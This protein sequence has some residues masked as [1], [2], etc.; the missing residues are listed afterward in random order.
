MKIQRY[1]FAFLVLY[2]S[3]GF[4][5]TSLV[6][7]VK[8]AI[9][10]RFDEIH[11]KHTEEPKGIWYSNYLATLLDSRNLPLPQE[12][13][14]G[15]CDNRFFEKIDA[16]T[17]KL[18]PGVPATQA[19]QH[20]IDNL[21]ILECGTVT[22]LVYYL[23]ISDVVGKEVFDDYVAKS[24]KPLY[25]ASYVDRAPKYSLF[26]DFLQQ[27]QIPS[28]SKSN[29]RPVEV[30]QL[31]YFRNYLDYLSR[32]PTGSAQGY[33]SIYLGYNAQGEQYYIAFWNEKPKKESEIVTLLQKKYYASLDRWDTQY[34]MQY[35]ERKRETDADPHHQFFA[36]KGI[37][38]YQL[39]WDAI[40]KLQN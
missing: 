23:A 22:Q 15:Y 38:S 11:A 40:E 33:N 2:A 5:E 9:I 17:F 19:C 1:F 28:P 29:E 20:L 30:G 36:D 6:E 25:I 27:V 39:K 24:E 12:D 4:T 18:R 34:F 35:P 37:Y 10:Q 16:W 31:V 32:H 7:K 26:H 13:W 21:S 14:T 3:Y 8:Y